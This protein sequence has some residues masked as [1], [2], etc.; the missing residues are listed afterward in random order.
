MGISY[1]MWHGGG[2]IIILA[3][4]VVVSYPEQNNL[5]QKME[6]DT[7]LQSFELFH[8]SNSDSFT[9]TFGCNFFA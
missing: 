7:D 6:F 8:L 4:I 9:G 5:N 2:G 3:S 1:L